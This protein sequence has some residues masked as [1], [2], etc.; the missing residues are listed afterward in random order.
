MPFIEGFSSHVIQRGNNRCR[1]FEDD[2]DRE[3]FLLML[4]AASRRRD[5][6]IHGYVLMDTHFHLLTTP[7]DGASLSSAM[8]DLG[9]DYVRSFNRKY[10]RIGTLWSHRPRAI[11]ILD[12][13][14]WLTCLRYIEQNPVRAKMVDA[15]SAFRWS[16]YGTHAT[17]IRCEWLTPHALYL[18][19]GHTD[20]IRQ[21]VYRAICGEP[22]NTADL[23]AQRYAPPFPV[24]AKPRL[25]APRSESGPEQERSNAGA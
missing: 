20:A 23:I 5:L 4:A 2:E 10:D 3:R 16:S 13:R 22:L 11:P 15:P 9:R 1:I 7:E 19:L 21:S 25:T 6:T 24:G 12:E 14:Q 18:A 8:R 17:G